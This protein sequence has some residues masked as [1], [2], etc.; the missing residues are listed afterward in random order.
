MLALAASTVATSG[1]AWVR[2][3]HACVSV[4]GARDAAAGGQPRVVAAEPRRLE[5]DDGVW[6]TDATPQASPR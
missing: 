2:E 4:A 5:D 6:S 1:T 3:L